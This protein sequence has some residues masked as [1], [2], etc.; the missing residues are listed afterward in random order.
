MYDPA[1]IL[2]DSIITLDRTNHPHVSYQADWGKQFYDTMEYFRPIFE[3]KGFLEPRI[4]YE[5]LRREEMEYEARAEANEYEK[6]NLFEITNLQDN[7]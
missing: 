7:D 5:E 6:D 4:S 3:S 2:R 1:L